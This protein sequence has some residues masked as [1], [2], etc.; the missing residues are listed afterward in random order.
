MS[1]NPKY[2]RVAI[3][4][5]ISILHL[6]LMVLIIVVSIFKGM[7]QSHQVAYVAGFLFGSALIAFLLSYPHY[8][9]QMVIRNKLPLAK[10][11]AIKFNVFAGVVMFLI[12]IV[13]SINADNSS[14]LWSAIVGLILFGSYALNTYILVYFAPDNSAA[15]EG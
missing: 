10:M 5:A 7:D 6:I 3:A 14:W 11:K 15:T 9:F 8:L 12:N 1:E 4:K 2:L 13:V